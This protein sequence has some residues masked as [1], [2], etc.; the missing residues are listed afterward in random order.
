ME[1]QR[2]QEAV[3]ILWQYQETLMLNKF[4]RKKVIHKFTGRTTGKFA[5]K[6]DCSGSWRISRGGDD[7]PDRIGDVD[8]FFP[9]AFGQGFYEFMFQQELV[10]K[11]A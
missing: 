5:D 1:I 10:V 6:E 7:G 9:I 8:S 11:P 2:G 3:A 4:P